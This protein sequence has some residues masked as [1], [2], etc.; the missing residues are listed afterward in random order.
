MSYDFFQ[1][2]LHGAVVLEQR[3]HEVCTMYFAFGRSKSRGNHMK[4]NLEDK[5]GLGSHVWIKPLRLALLTQSDQ[6]PQQKKQN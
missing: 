2:Q 3:L 6:I 1:L 5:E 4:D